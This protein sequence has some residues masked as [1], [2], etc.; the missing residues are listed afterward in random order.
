[1][2]LSKSFVGRKRECGVWDF[3]HYNESANTSVCNV[4]NDKG[5]ECKQVFSG[6]NPTNL[7][8]HVQTMHPQTFV[9]LEKKDASRILGK[10]KFGADQASSSSAGGNQTI[11]DCLSRK[12]VTWESKSSEHVRREN[13]LVD[14]IIDTG[15]PTTVADNPKFRDFCSTLDPKFKAPG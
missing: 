9:E 4:M 15:Y 13:S 10:R 8:K 3:F 6:K 11:S 14:M 7:K 12:V 2:S 5:I 1:M